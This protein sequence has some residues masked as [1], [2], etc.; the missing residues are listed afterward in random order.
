MVRYNIQQF[1]NIINC[2][3]V[4]SRIVKNYVENVVFTLQQFDMLEVTVERNFY[5][6]SCLNNVMFDHS[7]S[8]TPTSVQLSIFY[9]ILN[10]IRILSFKF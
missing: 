10:S 8:C 6:K 3:F 7:I 2:A 1:S 4:F 5:A 9:L